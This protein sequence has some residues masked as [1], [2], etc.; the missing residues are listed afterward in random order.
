MLFSQ[1]STYGKTS[2]AGSARP[3]IPL[4][5]MAL[6]EVIFYL[7]GLLKAFPMIS[8]EAETRSGQFPK[9]QHGE[10]PQSKT[11]YRCALV[12]YRLQDQSVK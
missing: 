6:S 8:M 2:H 11:E 10:N 5:S 9:P 4:T 12:V 3:E 7:E 1:I